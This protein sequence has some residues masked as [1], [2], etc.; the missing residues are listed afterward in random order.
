MSLES[1]GSII[2]VRGGLRRNR[3]TLTSAQILAL[4]T[5]AVALVAAPGAGKYIDVINVV[6]KGPA[7]GGTAYTGANNVEIRYTDGSGAKATSDLAAA[8]LNSQTSRVDKATQAAVTAVA[9]AAVVAV[10]PTANPAAG[11]KPV[12]IEVYYRIVTI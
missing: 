2:S 12:T 11:N 3:V 1:R 10:V 8:W 5:T 9:N 6:G 7:S 4:H